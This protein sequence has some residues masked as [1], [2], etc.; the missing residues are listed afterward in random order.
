MCTCLNILN[1]CLHTEHLVNVKEKRLA[2]KKYYIF[3]YISDLKFKNKKSF[4][5]NIY[6]VFIKNKQLIK[7]IKSMQIYIKKKKNNSIVLWKIIF[8][9]VK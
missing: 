7:L 3:D 1:V 4:Q 8:S 5:S 6:E 2:T 9:F